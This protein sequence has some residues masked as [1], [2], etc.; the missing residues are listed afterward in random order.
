MR[1]FRRET[2]L[3]LLALFLG[4]TVR[5]VGLGSL[6]LSDPEAGWALQAL[7]VASGAR[8]PLGSQPAYLALT[9]ALFFAFGGA[10]NTLA[11]LIPAL[12]G[13]ALILVPWLFRESL[14]PRPAVILAFALALEPGLAA[15]SRQAG[16]SIMTLTFVLAAW[17]FWQRRQAGWSGACAGMALLSGSAV[18]PGLLGLVLS[19]ALLRPLQGAPRGQAGG[20]AG[21]TAI[22]LSEWGK[23]G[24]YALGSIFFVGT[25]FMSMPGGLSA[26]I[27]GLPE[28]ILGWTSASAVPVSVVLSSLVAYQPLGLLLALLAAVR[29]WARRKS[30]ARRLSVWMLVALLLTL[31]YPSRQVIDLAWMLIPLWALASLELARALNLPRE[32]RRE[33][34]AAVALSCIILVFAWLDFLALRRPGLLPDQ[35]ELRVWLLI[36]SLFLLLVSLLL[37]AVGWSVQAARHGTLWGL[38]AFLSVYSTAMLMAATGHRQLPNSAELWHPGSYQPM[39]SLLLRTVDDQSAWSDKDRNAQSVAIAGVDSA[40][41]RWL[42]RD[43]PLEIRA[44]AGPASDQAMLIT[45]DQPDLALAASYRGQSFVWRRTPVWSLFRFQEWL[46][47]HEITQ[48]SEFIILWVRSDLFPDARPRSSP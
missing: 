37:V 31:F 14:K 39:A 11:R 16:S 17:G 40:A 8:P 33:V 6:P 12:T 9:S 42:L 46:P 3:Y 13:S 48:E 38:T 25:A 15:L 2:G 43:R 21:M 32:D 27:A 30:R 41:L 5:L 47:F 7:D 34:L 36:G 29:G 45:P 10:T 18:W 19:W 28:Y 23:L 20:P 35:V 24:L 4:L 1:T 26:W 22:S 44:S